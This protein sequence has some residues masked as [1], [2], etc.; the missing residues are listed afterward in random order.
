MSSAAAA[1]GAFHAPPSSYSHVPGTGSAGS[2]AGAEAGTGG[3]A[4]RAGVV[5]AASYDW[6]LVLYLCVLAGSVLWLLVSVYRAYAR[7]RDAAARA[8]EIAGACV[9]GRV[10]SL[11]TCVPLHDVPWRTWCCVYLVVHTRSTA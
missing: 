10:S 5:H 3:G 9:T 11:S 8:P 2:G 1:R 4:A 6:G 7:R